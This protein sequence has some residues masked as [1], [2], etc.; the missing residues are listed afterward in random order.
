M[1]VFEFERRAIADAAVEATDVVPA[2]QKG[3]YA[4]PRLLVGSEVF[5]TEQFGFECSEERLTHRV[6]IRITRCPH[7]WLYTRFATAPAKGNGR[8]LASLVRMENDAL[9][10]SLPQCHVQR[11]QHQFGVQMV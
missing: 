9:V 11:A 5:S 4:S 7:R 3:E 1:Q 2:F 10:S 6:V 8:V